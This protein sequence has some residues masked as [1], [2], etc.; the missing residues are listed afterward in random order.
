MEGNEEIR[1]EVLRALIALATRDVEFRRGIWEDLEGT[2][3]RYGFA[4]SD[5]E[6]AQVRNVRDAISSSL[7]EDVYAALTRAYR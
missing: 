7:D 1:L 4:L 6:I 2:L 5:Q 3:T